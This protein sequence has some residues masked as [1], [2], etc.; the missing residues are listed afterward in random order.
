MPKKIK[1][2]E[3]HEEFDEDSFE[4][5]EEEVEEEEEVVEEVEKPVKKKIKLKKK[6]EEEVKVRYTA[7]ANPQRYGIVDAET[8]EV[9]AEGEHAILQSLA[10]IIERLE[11]IENTIGNVMES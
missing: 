10:N 8:E 7:F 5:D 2:E 4:E 9:V 1:I 3:E 11:R 6:V